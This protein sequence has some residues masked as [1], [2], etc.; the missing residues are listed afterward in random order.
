[1]PRRRIP[2]ARIRLAGCQI[3]SLEIA[4]ALAKALDML[5]EK[6][7]IGSVYIE[8][9]DCFVCPDINLLRMNRTPMEKVFANV[10]R[11]QLKKNLESGFQR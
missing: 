4:R 10:M 7:G 5:E 6:S 11:Q 8:M 9:N 1:M 3:K 2:V